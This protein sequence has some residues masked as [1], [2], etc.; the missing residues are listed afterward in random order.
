M[1]TVSYTH[2]DQ[3]WLVLFILTTYSLILVIEPHDNTALVNP[4]DEDDVLLGVAHIS[5]VDKVSI[6]D[7]WET[8]EVSFGEQTLL[9]LQ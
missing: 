5:G 3:G 8:N 1:D 2:A 4:T 7:H 6:A 9:T